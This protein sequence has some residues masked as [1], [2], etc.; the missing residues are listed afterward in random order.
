M[1]RDRN[2]DVDNPLYLIATPIGNLKEVTPRALEL[3]TKADIV[4]CEDTRNTYSLLQNF[5]IKVHLFSLR[6]HNEKS[7]SQYLINEIKNDK[8]VIYVSDAG[9]PCISDPGFILVK[10][11]L[12]NDIKVSTVSGSS[13]FLNGLVASGIDSEHFYFYGFLSS[14]ESLAKKELEVLKDVSSTII[15]YESPHRIGRTL[16]LLNEYLGDRRAV[17][18]RELTKRNEEYIRGSLKEFTAIDPTTLI[19]EMV[20]IVEGKQIQK[21]MDKDEIK[22]HLL[23][24]AKKHLGSKDIVEIVSH[25]TNTNKNEIYDLLLEIKKQ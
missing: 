10:E 18:A 11:C 22:K 6:E 17:I 24:L 21:E 23:Y 14:K 8:K 2:F 15:F 19:G 7:A 4:A 13:A 3:F 25:F 1:K 20:I 5:G 12:E 9:Y 16:S